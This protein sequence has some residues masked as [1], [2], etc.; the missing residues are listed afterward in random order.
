MTV[1]GA[2]R[3]LRRPSPIGDLK[4]RPALVR[5]VGDRRV[6]KL[7]R[8]HGRDLCELAQLTNCPRRHIDKATQA[9]LAAER[10]AP[11]HLHAHHFAHHTVT[12]LLALS[13]RPTDDLTD[14]LAVVRPYEGAT[15]SWSG[16]GCDR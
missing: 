8:R 9:L 7:V 13:G 4:A 12:E 11:E 1:A 2:H 14:S 5:L 6:T 3:L 15:G 16:T 10:L